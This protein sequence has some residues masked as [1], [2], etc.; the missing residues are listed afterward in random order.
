MENARDYFEG[1]SEAIK[2]LLKKNVPGSN[3]QTGQR[4]YFV[5]L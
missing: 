2:A 1:N 5:S 3:L 4:G